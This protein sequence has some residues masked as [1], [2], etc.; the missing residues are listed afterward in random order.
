MMYKTRKLAQILYI[1]VL[2][3]VIAVLGIFIRSGNNNALGL[4]DLFSTN[5]AHADAP[6]GSPGSEDFEPDSSCASSTDSGA[7]S[8]GGAGCSG[9]SC[10]G[11]EG[12]GAGGCEGEGY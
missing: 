5:I 8:C 12:G 2:G 11:E 1:F 9:G 6:S 10:N 7:G 3:V 4:E